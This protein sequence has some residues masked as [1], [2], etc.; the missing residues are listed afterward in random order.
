MSRREIHDRFVALMQREPATVVLVTHDVEE[1]L[2]LASQLLIL[3][4][5]GKLLQSGPAEHVRRHPISEPI[6]R[7]FEQVNAG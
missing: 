2:R 6:A 1:A 7:L 4:Q 3:G 5:G